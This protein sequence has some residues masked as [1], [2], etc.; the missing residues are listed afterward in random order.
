LR[1]E[2]QRYEV[3]VGLNDVGRELLAPLW[4]RRERDVASRERVSAAASREERSHHFA[5]DFAHQCFDFL[6][7]NNVKSSRHFFV[8]LVKK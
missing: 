3:F 6:V 1:R 7:T 5:H 8:P 4:P 2:R